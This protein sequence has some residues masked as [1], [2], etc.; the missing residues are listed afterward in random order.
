MQELQMS[1]ATVSGPVRVTIPANVAHNVK[2][3]HATIDDLVNR[4]GCP[5]CFSGADC[6][7]QLERDFVVDPASGQL[8]PNEGVQYRAATEKM[9]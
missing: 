7:F 3:L 6:L 9:A 4:L 1:R 8:R 5:Q 2:R